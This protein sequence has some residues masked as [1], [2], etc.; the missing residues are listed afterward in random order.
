MG[1]EKSLEERI[2]ELE[3]EN[4]ALGGS[5]TATRRRRPARSVL[6]A[7]LI[8]VAL[9]LTPVAVI[10]TWARAQLVDTDRFVSTF[11]P[12]AEDPAV[13]ALVVAR[14]TEAIEE[15]TDIPGLTADVFDGVRSLD[16]PPRAQ[17]ALTQ[18]EAPAA[19]GVEALVEQTVRRVVSSD[20]FADTFA[21]ALRVSHDQAVSL[22]QG[23]PDAA[24]QLESGGQLTLQLGPVVETVKQRLE[25]RGIGFAARIPVVD[26]GIPIAQADALVVIR[27][28]YALAVGVGTWLAW[29][30]AGMVVVG[31]LIA[32]RRA[33]ALVRTALG[34]AAVMALLAAGIG[35]GK[36]YVVGTLSPSVLPADAAEAI[37]TQ[38]VELLRSSA[39]A[40]VV[41]GLLVA[42]VAWC[43]GP[44]PG[45]TAA[46]R[47]AGGAIGRVRDTAERQGLSTGA[48]GTALD[49]GRTL[50]YA[51]IGA[52]AVLVV[53][54]ARPLGVSTVIGVVVAGAVL[55]LVVELV[56]RPAVSPESEE[57]APAGPGDD[58]G[59]RETSG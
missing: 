26:R 40:G 50:V 15:R 6:S 36:L 54:L 25:E 1:P 3:A 59:T 49:R 11:A 23:D 33:A 24:V 47:V 9:L 29:V 18:L 53:L 27:S 48:F 21:G 2:A 56:R 5:A 19:R 45:A 10:S 4:R 17:D 35:A 58:R 43:A 42:A 32:R 44:F 52:A 34:L 46:R 8:V 20:Q 30:L 14:T 51:A 22:I 37:Y 31:V 28:V 13:Q 57:A 55:L 39:V 16:L 38:V 7:V 12:L 41:L